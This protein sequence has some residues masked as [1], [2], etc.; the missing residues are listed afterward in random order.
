MK[1]SAFF[2]IALLAGTM[3]CTATDN[4]A[5]ELRVSAKNGM[6]SFSPHQGEMT[7]TGEL[8]LNHA[9]FRMSV[10]GRAT[11]FN[12]PALQHEPSSDPASPKRKITARQQCISIIALGDVTVV[13]I[14]GGKESQP[15][16]GSR[17]VYLPNED[18]MLIDGKE[19]PRPG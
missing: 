5:P 9:R 19:V 13:M 16:R 10:N 11:V 2:L 1:S 6:S 17:V 4:D 7:W 12:G 8:S 18:R 15:L 3:A 14:D